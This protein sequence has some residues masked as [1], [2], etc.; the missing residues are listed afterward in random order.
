MAHAAT[1]LDLVRPLRWLSGHRNWRA[2]PSPA[3]RHGIKWGVSM[4]LCLWLGHGDILG[5]GLPEPSWLIFTILFVTL[6]T[7]GASIQKAMYRI[8]G[9][10][11][12]ALAALVIWRV[13]A[14]L[15]AVELAGIFL[16][17]TAGIYWMVGPRSQYIGNVMAFTTGTILGAAYPFTD[18]QIEDIAFDRVT[19]VMIGIF[20]VFVVD[21]FFWPARAG[22]SLRKDLAQ[23]VGAL[24][25]RLDGTLDALRAGR[26][27][28]DLDHASPTLTAELSVVEQFRMEVGITRA[29]ADAAQRMT[30]LLESIGLRSRQLHDVLAALPDRTQ[31][32]AF[33]D[34]VGELREA[35]HEALNLAGEALLEEHATQFAGPVVEA[36]QRIQQERTDFATGRLASDEASHSASS[37][38]ADSIRGIRAAPILR[39]IVTMIVRLESELMTLNGAKSGLPTELRTDAK[40]HGLRLRLDVY[41][42]QLALRGGLAVVISLL[43]VVSAGWGNNAMVMTIAYATAASPTFRS[44]KGATIMLLQITVVGSIIADISLVY[45]MEYLQRMPFAL[46]YPFTLMAVLGYLVIQKPKPFAGIAAILAVFIIPPIFAPAAVP[47]DVYGPYSTASYVLMGS[48]AALFAAWAFWPMTS[49]QIFWKRSAGQLD[50]CR[51]IFEI[52]R[53]GGAG[54]ERAPEL[55]GAYTSQIA[56]LSKLHGEARQDYDNGAA[57]DKRRAELLTRTQSV[58]AAAIQARSTSAPCLETASRDAGAELVA[59]QDALLQQDDAIEASL[60][61]TVAAL[62]GDEVL[63][64]ELLAE[65]HLAAHDKCDALI[66]DRDLA[67]RLGARAA[68]QVIAHAD[69]RSLLASAQLDIEDWITRWRAAAAAT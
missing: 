44:A 50:L 62:Q 29:Q 49:T 58:F 8:I 7:E 27:P 56:N 32:E 41:Q 9:T 39:D 16:V 17:Y 31:P 40:P 48:A 38:R 47:L 59:L 36:L 1:E 61:T 68:A 67:R 13:G 54:I 34:A 69:A 19:L 30:L 65:A 28:N 25:D 15:P 21:S 64:S 46:I 52:G 57:D 55:V 5:Y 14:Q 26:R 22:V 66:G 23:R 3:V 35:V 24:R 10:L 6:P 20:I 12:G 2:A 51:Q 37:S 33:Q 45:L 53:T 60:Q 4:A 63:T 18:G 43:L 11:A 42:L